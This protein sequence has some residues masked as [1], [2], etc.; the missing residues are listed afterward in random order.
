MPTKTPTG[1]NKNIILSFGHGHRGLVGAPITSKIV[2]NFIKN[3]KQNLN[4]E[5]FSINRFS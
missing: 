4:V 3:N 5:P 2:L 1:N